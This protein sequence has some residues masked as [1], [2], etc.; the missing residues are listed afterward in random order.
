MNSS[1]PH[2]LQFLVPGV[3]LLLPDGRA[4]RSTFLVDRES[5]KR[6][7]DGSAEVGVMKFVSAVE[8]VDQRQTRQW[9]TK[10]PDG[11]LDTYE[12]DTCLV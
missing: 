5:L 7:V 8:G 2:L 3:R 9:D 12:A 11:V 10:R 1:K 4:E 6:S